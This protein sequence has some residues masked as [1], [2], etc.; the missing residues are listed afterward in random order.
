[1]IVALALILRRIVRNAALVMNQDAS[2]VMVVMLVHRHR[3]RGVEQGVGVP[4]RRGGGHRQRGEA[5]ADENPQGGEGPPHRG[6]L[7]GPPR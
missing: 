4:V 1:M 3:V 7:I 2:I 6:L 5:Q